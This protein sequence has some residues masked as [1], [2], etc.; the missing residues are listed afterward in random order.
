DPWAE[1]EEAF[2]SDDF[3]EESGEQS[4]IPEQEISESHLEP[5]VPEY[6]R[7]DDLHVPQKY[8]GAVKERIE[9]AA[10]I[11]EQKLKGETEG[12][13][14]ELGQQKQANQAFLSVFK[15]IAS[16]PER[17]AYYVEK[18]GEAVGIDKS[19]LRMPRQE[20]VNPAPQVNLESIFEKYAGPMMKAESG[21]QFY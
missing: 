21:E 20:E 4:A 17:I 10:Q 6:L 18:Y 2:S 8:K 3:S 13:H 11:I 12:I 19:S 7:L 14:T 9:K 1:A 15:D 5:E 16:N